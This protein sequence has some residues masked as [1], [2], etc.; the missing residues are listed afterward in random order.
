MRTALCTVLISLLTP[1]LALACGGLFCDGGTPIPVEQ[2]GE[3]ILFE[4]DPEN[5]TVTTTVDIQ[6]GG[7][8]QAFSW[9]L[10]IP[11][12]D[13]MPVP[14]LAITPPDLLRILEIATVPTII[15][16]QTKCTGQAPNVFG[17]AR[18]A[19]APED[20]A[21]FDDDD[22][23]GVDVTDLP[24]VGPYDNE[25][26]QA[27]DAQALIDWLNTNGYL[28]TPSMEPFIADYVSD[29]LAFLGVKLVAGADTAEIAPL[30]VTW[31]GTAPMIPLRLTSIAAEP[32]MGILVF[33]LGDSNYEASNWTSM[34]ID[35]DRLQSNPLSGQDNYHS[36]LSLELDE[37]GGQGFVTE[38]SADSTAISGLTS[39]ISQFAAGSGTQEEFDASQQALTEML[40]RR[41][42]LT[43]FHGRAHPEEMVSDPMFG[44]SAA[45]LVS[46]VFD[47][48]ERPKI[49]A[50]GANAAFDLVPCGSTYCGAGGFCATTDAG[51]EGCG[52]E[53]GFVAREVNI[54]P[55]PGQA[56]VPSI[57]CQDD[58]WDFLAADLGAD[59]PDPCAFANCGQFGECAAVNGFATCACDEG[60]AAVPN[61]G[62]PVC[63]AIIKAYTPDQ[64]GTWGACDGGCNAAD[65]EPTALLAL[66]L[67]VMGLAVRRRL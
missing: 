19:S 54:A 60:Y 9:L 23:D 26:I 44:P 22:D 48:S 6:Y 2:S 24:T 39:G 4:V 33:I 49:E 46:G 61:A 42:F 5:L 38:M 52:C 25:L 66:L 67:G 43:R 30:S 15:P 40:G 21:A 18:G 29:G 35:I 65:E 58:A 57:V 59:A 64:I 62:S 12:S 63:S 32:E 11:V 50:C 3:R 51:I 34:E 8:P 7:E 55:V 16:P 36:L 28:V 47:L 14:D 27:G 1:G 13:A 45:P 41:D 53:P 17:G 56:E 10:P 20:A 37:V 31:P